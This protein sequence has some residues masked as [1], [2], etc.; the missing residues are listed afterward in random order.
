MTFRLWRCLNWVGGCQF[1]LWIY[2]LRYNCSYLSNVQK[3]LL[4]KQGWICLS[5]RKSKN[6]WFS[7]K[8][9]WVW[10]RAGDAFWLGS[11]RSDWSLHWRQRHRTRDQLCLG[12]RF[13]LVIPSCSR[14]SCSLT[15]SNY[16]D[17]QMVQGLINRVGPHPGSQTW[18]G[19]SWP[20]GTSVSMIQRTVLF[21]NPA[22]LCPGIQ[23]YLT[24]RPWLTSQQNDSVAA[25]FPYPN[26]KET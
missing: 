10:V 19:P 23:Y 16:F 22:T 13:S 3:Y 1:W 20:K 25:I 12:K 5:E 9:G 7:L 15:N 24:I 4:L 18:R 6:K 8:Q 21:C 11:T 17:F 14:I 2:H 26:N